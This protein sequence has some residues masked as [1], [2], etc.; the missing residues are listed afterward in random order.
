MD[1]NTTNKA[2]DIR[3]KGYEIT[4]VIRRKTFTKKDKAVSERVAARNGTDAKRAG[5]FNKRLFAKKH[6]A[7]INSIAT[8]IGNYYREKTLPW[9]IGG[10][11]ILPTALFF[12]FRK[13]MTKKEAEFYDAVDEFIAA[14][15]RAVDEARIEL[16]GLFNPADYKDPAKLRESFRI[17]FEH[18][19][20]ADTGDFRLEL[21]GIAVER[22]KSEL[23]ADYARKLEKAM[24]DIRARLIKELKKMRDGLDEYTADHEKNGDKATKKLMSAW[25][26][27]V[28]NVTDAIPTLNLTN[29][30]TLDKLKVEVE[31]LLESS[32]E[33]SLKASVDSRKKAIKKADD[34]LGKM[35]A[36]A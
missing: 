27:N 2:F 20:I 18:R 1:T 16:N 35:G 24:G 21:S 7:R 22:L 23:E 31:E 25:A 19:P 28:R 9:G 17:E 11:R 30:P 33:D 6:L 4:L 13:W 36:F 3:S 15:P 5:N 14:Y 26:S 29:D 32:S 34:I 8:E 10:S 12:E